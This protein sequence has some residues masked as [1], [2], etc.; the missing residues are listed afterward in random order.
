MK[1]A[2]DIVKSGN[3]LRHVNG[4]KPKHV[5]SIVNQWQR[6]GL[7]SG[8]LKNRLSAVRFLAEKI[9]KP[10]IV[11]SNNELS[12]APRQRTPKINRAIHDPDFSAVDNKHILI[13]LQL[14]RVFGLRR[15][16]SLKIRPHLADTGNLLILQPT[17]CK[18]GRGRNVPIRTEDQRY[19]LEQAK[20]LVARGDSIIPPD[21]KYI[22]QRNIY[23]KQTARAGIRNPHGLRHA[24]AQR[25]YK[26]L[27]GWEA[28][29][30]GGPKIQ[31][32][33]M[34]QRETDHEARLI[35]SSELGHGRK[36]VV[37]NYLAK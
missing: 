32:L 7:S 15:E 33:T 34:E 29:I 12:I 26:E 25:R 13:S 16:E 11:P 1:F 36:E 9:G 23:D 37:E 8:T 17:W 22:Q 30:N 18:G 19:W 10:N 20:Q 5:L 3:K 21:M 31:E 6:E 4:L 14:Q 28:P 2:E 35:I 24:Y 27:T